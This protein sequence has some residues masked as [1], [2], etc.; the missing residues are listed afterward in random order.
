[1]IASEKL[2]KVTS[3]F[4]NCTQVLAAIGDETRQQ[5]LITIMAAGCD[6]VRVG[7]IT[8]QTHLSRPAVSHHLKI[9]RE[10]GIV[11]MYKVT[12]KNYYYIDPTS[13]IAN[14]KD[15]ITHMEDILQ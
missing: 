1:M 12:T 6:G 7:D 4:K 10:A 15:L 8:A 11:N 2:Y 9:L 14:L 3:D 5:I 13:W